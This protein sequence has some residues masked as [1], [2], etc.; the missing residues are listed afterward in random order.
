MMDLFGKGSLGYWLGGFAMMLPLLFLATAA[1]SVNHFA[2]GAVWIISQVLF[3]ESIRM[4]TEK[5]EKRIKE[6]ENNP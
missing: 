2:L 6:L 5:Y 1:P 3:L 4:L